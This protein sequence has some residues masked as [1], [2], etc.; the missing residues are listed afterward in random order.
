MLR[1]F[2]GI[3][4]V[5]GMWI[6][7]AAKQFTTWCAGRHNST[8]VACTASAYTAREIWY[9]LWEFQKLVVHPAKPAVDKSCYLST[10][11]L[12][13]QVSAVARSV[14]SDMVHQTD[15]C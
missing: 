15:G 4:V 1:R 6:W 10:N 5:F 14:V 11:S 12:K 7:L 8:C 2:L 9:C 3:G 13:G